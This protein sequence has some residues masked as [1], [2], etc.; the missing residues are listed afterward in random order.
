MFTRTPKRKTTKTFVVVALDKRAVTVVRG[1][2]PVVLS[3]WAMRKRRIVVA[4][5]LPYRYLLQFLHRTH[6]RDYSYRIQNTPYPV[7]TRVPGYPASVPLKSTC[8]PRV[9]KTTVKYF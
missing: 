8:V 6:T 5:L 7:H 4:L 9:L 1:I 2:R 3:I